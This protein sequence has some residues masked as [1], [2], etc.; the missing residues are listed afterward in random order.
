MPT[1]K[2]YHKNKDYYDNYRK[3]NKD[4][5]DNYYKNYPKD[6]LKKTKKKSEWKCS[7]KMK[8]DLDELYDI[9]IN[10][11]NCDYCNVLLTEERKITSTRKCME[12][13]HTTGYFRAVCCHSCNCKMKI[14][15]EKY[16]LVIK[17]LK[18]IPTLL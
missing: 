5:Y 15:D 10:K 8:G 7:Y 18:N 3:E 12:H 13:N 6:K 17:T 1:K 9:Y 14:I 2:E 16:N 11:T 4:Y